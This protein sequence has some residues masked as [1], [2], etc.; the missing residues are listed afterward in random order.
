MIVGC[1]D[2]RVDPMDI[3]KLDRGEGVVIRNV[4]GRINLALL[5]TLTIL[6]T[7]SKAAGQELAR[8]GI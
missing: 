6:R 4:G 2:P 7:V 3:L 5:E 1:V 8:D